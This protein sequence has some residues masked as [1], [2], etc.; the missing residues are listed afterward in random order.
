MSRQVT[1]QSL[2]DKISTQLAEQGEPSPRTAVDPS[3]P[4]RP[5]SDAVGI[6]RE[7]RARNLLPVLATVPRQPAAVKRL[8]VGIIAYLASVA[9]VATATISIFFGVGL[10]SLVKS[11][12]VMMP[13][14]VN[15][16]SS[17]AGSP[18]AS[19]L[20]RW[21]S[22]S[23]VI[24]A[25]GV[26]GEPVLFESAAVATL[27]PA[28]P[29]QLSYSNQTAP[30]RKSAA[31]PPAPGADGPAEVDRNA[32]SGREVQDSGVTASEPAI[33]RVETPEPA[34]ASPE[35]APR[36]AA[37][38]TAPQQPPRLLVLSPAEVGELLT[39]G[40]AFLRVGDLTSARLFYQRAAD[41]GN[42]QGAMRMGATFDPSFL[43][44]AGLGGAQANPVEAQAWYRKAADLRTTNVQLN[45][46]A[47]EKK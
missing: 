29:A 2:T 35:L 16:Q 8:P 3:A 46:G 7:V 40:D 47:A 43:G 45:P 39:R 30:P 32:S 28:A 37:A 14:T 44:R 23:S 36:A 31:A 5:G 19:L 4:S 12:E 33:P 24:R 42:G 34:A 41:A 11:T 17:D 15:D 1:A 9:L 26:P 38:A 22:P 10:L 13:S 20:S 27:P 18:F 25:A 6:V 21:F